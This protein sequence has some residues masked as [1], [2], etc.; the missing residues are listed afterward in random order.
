MGTVNSRNCQNRRR[1]FV[2]N[3]K[4]NNDCHRYFWQFVHIFW[5]NGR[6]RKRQHVRFEFQRNYRPTIYIHKRIN[7]PDRYRQ[8]SFLLEKRNRFPCRQN[9][10]TTVTH[11]SHRS[12]NH[13]RIARW[14]LHECVRSA[15][16]YW[17]RT[18][19][20]DRQAIKR[21]QHWSNTFGH[22]LR[23]RFQSF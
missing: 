18:D 3:P 12:N 1:S 13:L 20:I 22:R 9:R 19:T 6:N 4:R 10:W 16:S 5:C 15:I 14:P 23:M 7:K 2:R 21:S 8:Y 17:P 11:Q